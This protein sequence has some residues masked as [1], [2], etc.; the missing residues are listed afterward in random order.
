MEFRVC[1]VKRFPSISLSAR[2][3]SLTPALVS[4]CAAALTIFSPARNG[5]EVELVALAEGGVGGTF[6]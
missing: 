3:A 2:A 4:L 1:F 6:S 5:W